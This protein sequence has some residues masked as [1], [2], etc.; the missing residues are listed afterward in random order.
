MTNIFGAADILLPK[1]NEIDKWAVIA[2][3][4]FTSQPEYWQEVKTNV[5]DKPSTLNLV[6]PE[7]YL[8]PGY[9]KMIPVINANMEKYLQENLLE[10]YA[11]SYVYVERTLLNGAIRCGL[12][13]AIDLETYSYDSKA[14]CAIR[15][16]EQTVLERIPPRVAIREN[17]PVEL[18]HII[19]FC[20]DV[21][22]KLIGTCE[23]NKATYPVLYDCE[24][25]C[26]S[27]HITGWLIQGEAKQTIDKCFADYVAACETKY[28]GETPVVLAVGD[29]NHSLATAKACYEK[30][31]A[32]LSPEEAANHPAR[33]ALV[34][35]ENIQDE[36][37]AFEPIHRIITNCD[38]QKLVTKMEQA[39][40]APEGFEV[41]WLAGAEHGLIKVDPAKG[42]LAV[43]TV[44]DFLDGYLV[45]ESGDIDYIHG[46]DTVANLAK[47]EKTVG[48]ILPPFAKEALFDSIQAQGA[49]PRKTFSIGHAQE[50]RYYLEARKIR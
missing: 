4:Q 2:C 43:K 3:D 21:E 16:T 39:I 6:L 50:K 41:Q 37:Q 38:V 17:A 49:L 32:Q 35:V 12:L 46:E 30:L 20:D 8:Q 22:D 42:K 11:D 31:K 1:T 48:L 9:E 25:M 14:D 7:C 26:G 36:A 40:G 34:E 18:P 13:G 10:C 29:G 45:Q 24:L 15:A 47:Q 33:Y 27:G 23:A 5:G 28:A 44:Q 19:L